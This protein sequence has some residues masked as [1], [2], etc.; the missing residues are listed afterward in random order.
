MMPD[1]VDKITSWDCRP[2]EGSQYIHSVFYISNID[3][4]LLNTCEFACFY[5]ECMDDNHAFYEE[6]PH[7]NHKA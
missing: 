2:I 4:T 7:V 1:D 5:V 6:K 3:V